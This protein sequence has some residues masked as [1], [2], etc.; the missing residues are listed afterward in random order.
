MG[1]LWKIY[2]SGTYFTQPSVVT[3]A[4]N[5]NSGVV[6]GRCVAFGNTFT[7]AVVASPN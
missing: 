1:Y 6:G 3:V 5:L 4:A 7:A 2:T